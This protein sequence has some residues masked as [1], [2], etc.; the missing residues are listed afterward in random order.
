[1]TDRVR[2][3]ALTAARWGDFETLFGPRGACAGCWCMWWRLPRSEW[4]RGK[5]EGNRRAMRKIVQGGAP[6]G[7]LAYSGSTPAGWIA[8]APRE[9]TPGLERSRTLKPLD[10]ERVWSITCF[11]VAR[12]FRKQGLTVE[13]LRGAAAY[14][15]KK[16]IRTL[17]G[18][19]VE[20][21]KGSVQADAWVYTGVAG[22][23]R[24]AGFRE[25][26]RPTETRRIMRLE[27]R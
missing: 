16:K 1:M 11:F 22:A 12:G 13:L 17:E 3:V 25:V 8:L 21:K 23:F 19:P 27:V 18:Y 26:A 20:P 15:R 5:G 24:K 6:T 4:T 14:A 7:L 2:I 10:D 9:D